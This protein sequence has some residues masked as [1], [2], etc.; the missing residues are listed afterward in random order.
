MNDHSHVQ[1]ALDALGD[2]RMYSFQTRSGL[3]CIINF[4][5][6]TA[7][8]F[9]EEPAEI[10]DEH[11][12]NTVSLWLTGRTKELI[13]EAP[14]NAIRDFM[15]HIELGRDPILCLGEWRIT[16]NRIVVAVANCPSS[17]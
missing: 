11:K 15:A 12:Q 2:G 17:A 4:A 10:C 5:H 8:K 6:V 9:S 14:G 1:S 3:S 13:I 16:A 7:S